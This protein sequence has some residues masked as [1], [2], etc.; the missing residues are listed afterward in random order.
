[1][2]KMKQKKNQSHN[3]SDIPLVI[4]AGGKGS[5]LH[6]YTQKIPKPLIKLKNKPLIEIIINHY[7]NYGV[8][9]FII[10]GGYKYELFKKHFKQKKNVIVV[11]TGRNSLTGKRIKKIEKYV[12]ENFF[13]LTYGDGISD[14]NIKKLYSF[15]L[16]HKK[17]ATMT[18]VRPPS[19]FGVLNIK[20]QVLTSLAEKPQLSTGWINGGYF[21][22]KKEFFKLLDFKNVMLERDPM[23]KLCKKKQINVYLHDKF[24]RCV[25]TARDLKL[26]EEMNLNKFKW[27]NKK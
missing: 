23:A 9:K 20:N 10:A 16:K 3:L 22:F 14:I 6:E 19:R 7:E 26:L 11:N 1:M 4:L 2:T 5:R 13:F 8:K 21:V 12:S 17:I 25:D 15:H 27:L 18:G 24:W